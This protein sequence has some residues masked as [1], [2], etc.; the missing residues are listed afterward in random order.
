[1]YFSRKSSRDS[2]RVNGVKKV[3]PSLQN[4]T[5]RRIP[6]ASEPSSNF[7]Q[8]LLPARVIIRSS[9]FRGQSF[10]VTGLQDNHKT[11]IIELLESH[12]GRVL[13]DYPENTTE[14]LLIIGHASGYRRPSYITAVALSMPIIHSNWVSLKSSDSP[15]VL[16][17]I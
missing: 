4:N 12:A 17:T 8:I 11:K 9:L 10:I 15:F 2:P 7:P 13:D 16:S 3:S 14:R 5:E 6:D 1:M